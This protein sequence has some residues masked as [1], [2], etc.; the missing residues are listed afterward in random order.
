VPPSPPGHGRYLQVTIKK[1]A[2]PKHTCLTLQY[3]P[4][5]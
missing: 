5:H 2:K 4:P 3:P 1:S